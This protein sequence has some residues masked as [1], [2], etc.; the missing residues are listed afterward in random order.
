M[1]SSL[2]YVTAIY[3][4]AAA[5][6]VERAFSNSVKQRRATRRRRRSRQNA[7]SPQKGSDR[8]PAPEPRPASAAGVPLPSPPARIVAL[9]NG[10]LGGIADDD[11]TATDD[12]YS[13]DG[14]SNDENRAPPSPDAAYRKGNTALVATTRHRAAAASPGRLRL[15][16]SAGGARIVALRA[17]GARLR[18]GGERLSDAIGQGVVVFAAF[19]R[20]CGEPSLAAA[21]RGLLHAPLFAGLG[22][23][24]SV[25]AAAASATPVT[26]L[27]VPQPTLAG[28][29]TEGTHGA[30]CIAY[31][32]AAPAA[33]GAALFA[34]FE[35]TLRRM[36]AELDARGDAARWLTVTAGEYGGRHS[37]QIDAGSDPFVHCFST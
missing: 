35:H 29:V 15:G 17:T 21:A 9:R 32:G 23:P 37:L 28:D 6:S 12:C 7:S 18:V 3:T 20:N 36:A 2:R 11:D 4:A 22:G 14:R 30:C 8:Y 34:A 5:A 13:D 1:L 25:A 33:R 16:R 10:A 24:T 19:G 31:D 27:I 26:V